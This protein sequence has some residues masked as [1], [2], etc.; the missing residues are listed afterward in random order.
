M[1]LLT[2]GDKELVELQLWLVQGGAM[3]LLL[4]LIAA[5]SFLVGTDLVT[6]RQPPAS[7]YSA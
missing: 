1:V 7:P 6:S 5:P 3:P 4:H 2:S